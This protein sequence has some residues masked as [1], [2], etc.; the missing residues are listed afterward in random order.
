M[1]YHSEKDACDNCK[2]EEWGC[3]Q[4]PYNPHNPPRP[5]SAVIDKPYYLTYVHGVPHQVDKDGRFR[6]GRKA[7]GYALILAGTLGEAKAKFGRG[8]VEERLS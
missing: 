1:E 4:H 6:S 3:V 8:E 7:D 5:V 2:D